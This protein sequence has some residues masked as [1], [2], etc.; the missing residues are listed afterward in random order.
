MKA[1]HTWQTT[2]AVSPTIP[3][4]TTESTNAATAEP[5]DETRPGVTTAPI[6]AE[7][8]DNTP[9]PTAPTDEEVVITRKTYSLAGQVIAVR[10][11]GDPDGN[12]GLH[13]V[14][15]DH[16][17]SAS[18]VTDA[19]GNVQ[20]G[21]QRYYSFGGYRSGDGFEPITDR[22]FTGHRENRD[23]GLTYMNARFYV[24]SI[25]RFASA[26]TIVSDPA[27][28]QS[29]NRYSYAINNPLKYTDPTGHAYDAGGAQSPISCSSGTAPL[30]SCIYPENYPDPSKR[31]YAIPMPSPPTPPTWTEEA[32]QLWNTVMDDPYFGGEVSW[33]DPIG[34]I[35]GG[36]SGTFAGYFAELLYQG[37]HDIGGAQFFDAVGKGFDG[38]STAFDGMTY[39]ARTQA[40]YNAWMDPELKMTSHQLRYLNRRAIA[41]PLFSIG[42]TGGSAILGGMPGVAVSAGETVWS[43][44]ATNENQL[45]P[46]E[47]LAREKAKADFIGGP[48]FVGYSHESMMAQF[49]LFADLITAYMVYSK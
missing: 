30:H 26:D 6:P 49:E 15:S 13:Y 17:G 2:T 20:G 3:L 1:K 10:I 34:D 22:G 45:G 42:I 31:G 16:L 39:A 18:V 47:W 46:D 11:G 14:Y 40:I 4:T 12:D 7:A 35:V 5:P 21:V 37:G 43:V 8:D 44:Y 25:A 38:F 29:L 24:P 36:G 19:A 9:T 23:I 32:D 48:S 27:N 33:L 28:P 41:E